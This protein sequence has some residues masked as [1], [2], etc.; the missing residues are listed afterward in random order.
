MAA[1]YSGTLMAAN[2]H[3]HLSVQSAHLTDE[4]PDGFDK[5]LVGAP[6]EDCVR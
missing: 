2:L 4:G 6:D 1:T 3:M 5:S